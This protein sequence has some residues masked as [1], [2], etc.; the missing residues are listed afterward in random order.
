VSSTRWTRDREEIAPELIAS[1]RTSRVAASH[2][3]TTVYGYTYGGGTAQGGEPR[4]SRR[5]R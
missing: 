3:R 2:S 1:V 5:A 4:A